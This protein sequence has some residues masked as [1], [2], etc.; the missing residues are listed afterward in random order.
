M[1][2]D[3]AAK[4]ASALRFARPWAGVLFPPDGS[5]SQDARQSVAFMYGGILAGSAVSGAS[6][7][8][9][10]FGAR[11]LNQYIKHGESQAVVYGGAEFAGVA[12]PNSDDIGGGG[13]GGNLKSWL[14]PQRVAIAYVEVMENGQMVR[15]PAYV[16][17]A[18]WYKFFTFV[19]EIKLGGVNGPTMTNVADDVVLAKAQVS[20]VVAEQALVTQQVQANAEALKVTV[21]VSQGA[22]LAGAEQIPDVVVRAVAP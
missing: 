22:A 4:R 18:T 21:E 8:R 19:A 14:P 16:D 6:T 12:L 9:I 13:G 5:V 17:A 7:A 15:K 10:Y 20:T 2:I 11:W 3:T 1:A